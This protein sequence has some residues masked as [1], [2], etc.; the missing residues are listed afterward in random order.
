[1]DLVPQQE[2]FGADASTRRDAEPDAEPEVP[3]ATKPA[4][5]ASVE[6]DSGMAGKPC[7]DR[8]EYKVSGVPY[9]GMRATCDGLDV[10]IDGFCVPEPK[11]ETGRI[12][13]C[14][15]TP[16]D[17]HGKV[18]PNSAQLAGEHL[19][20]LEQGG[21]DERSNPLYDGAL[22][23]AKV[24]E[25]E[26]E[27]LATGLDFYDENARKFLGSVQLKISNGFAVWSDDSYR[28]RP[29]RALAIH[30]PNAVP[31]DLMPAKLWSL[32]WS[33]GY[34]YRVD[35][36]AVRSQRFG[37]SSIETLVDTLQDGGTCVAGD[38]YLL[39]TTGGDGY[40]RRIPLDAPSQIAKLA[41]NSYP[42]A[43]EGDQVWLQLADRWL[44]V[45]DYQSATNLGP[46]SIAGPGTL[47]SLT[48]AY[49]MWQRESTLKSD[50]SNRSQVFLARSPRDGSGS[51]EVIAEAFDKSVTGSNTAS[52][53]GSGSAAG[54]VWWV[55][56][57]LPIHFAP[58]PPASA[59]LNATAD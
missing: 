46:T 16:T 19:Y 49:V 5:D 37:S 42:L 26:R 48:D 24:G 54:V 20:W 21:T 9:R 43:L 53:A 58:M 35:K 28:S 7:F 23:R 52:W 11:C 29:I 50:G 30:E 17:T 51:Q 36:T 12:E 45:A 57:K 8:G 39:V 27:E 4:P 34:L 10:C 31:L 14:Q 40:L 47:L 44:G 56:N 55:R 15:F 59:A 32:C 13:A 18:V 1:M 38:G 3:D 22:V 41:L 25:W 2:P 33:D 6:P